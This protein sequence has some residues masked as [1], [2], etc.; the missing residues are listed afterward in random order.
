MTLQKAPN[1]LRLH[2]HPFGKEY[3]FHVHAKRFEIDELPRDDEKLDQWLVE[4]FV[5]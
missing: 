1:I 5:E 4:R 3:K 2:T